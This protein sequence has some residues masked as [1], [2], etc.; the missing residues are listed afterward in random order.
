MDSSRSKHQTTFLEV[1]WS[2]P[3]YYISST[4]PEARVPKSRFAHFLSNFYFHHRRIMNTFWL[5]IY[6]CEDLCNVSG[7]LDLILSA[8]IVEFH[9]YGTR[10]LHFCFHTYGPFLSKWMPPLNSQRVFKSIWV[11]WFYVW[12]IFFKF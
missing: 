7:W 5:P 10:K 1:I 3:D 12:F 11:V 4:P 9:C 6:D 8:G 2:I